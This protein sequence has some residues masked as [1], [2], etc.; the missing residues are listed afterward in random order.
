MKKY[1][2]VSQNKKILSEV[3]CNSCGNA[4]EKTD[5]GR[6]HDYLSVEKSWGYL[7][8][9]DGEVH[10]FDLCVGCYRGIVEQFDTVTDLKS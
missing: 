8:E 4:I 5:S 6:F 9:F 1:T 7:S 2:E 3:I 10:E